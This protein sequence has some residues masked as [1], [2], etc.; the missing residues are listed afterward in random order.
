MISSKYKKGDQKLLNAWAIYDWANSAYPLV[1]SSAVFP[2]YYGALF[3]DDLYIEL[4]G[5]N[6]KNT[7]LIS[8]LTAFA[9]V[10]LSFITPLLSGIADYMGNKKTFLKIFCYVGSLSCMGLYWFDLTNIYIG[11]SFYFLALISFWASLVFYNSY[12]P[13]IALKDQQDFISAKGYALGYFG[14]VLLLIFDLAMVMYPENFGI[15]GENPELL[16]MRYSFVSVGIWWISFSQYTFYLLHNQSEKK[17]I[18][19]DVVWNGFKELVEVWNELKKIIAWSSTNVFRKIG[20]CWGAQAL[21]KVLHNI[22]KHSIKNKLFGVYDHNLNQEKNYRLMHGFIDRFPMPVS[23][24]TENKE[25]EILKAGLEVL[26]FS[27]VS[28][29]G[30]VRCPQ[31][32]DLFI[33]NHLEYDAITLKDEFVRDKSAKIDISVPVNYFPNDDTTKEPINRWRPY[34]FLLFTNFINE[35]YQDV[36]FDFCKLKIK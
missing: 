4:L 28:G 19:K 5:F 17:K 16:A 8:F 13:D 6:F 35:V 23:R 29:I 36:P 34:A 7:A 12:L 2:I 27:K 20:I 10:I 11:L 25:S 1:I 3:F 14:S 21:L 24:F 31:T 32:K 22:E 18:I 33:F 9:F 26:A 30:M 15:T